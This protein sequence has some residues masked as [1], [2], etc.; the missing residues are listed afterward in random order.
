MKIIVCINCS[1]NCFYYSSSTKRRT[2][3]LC[4]SDLFK[5]EEININEYRCVICGKPFDGKKEDVKLININNK[6]YWCKCKEENDKNNDLKE[7]K[8][9]I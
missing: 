5:E 1:G 4:G 7:T 8:N 6:T 2:C 9:I 3:L